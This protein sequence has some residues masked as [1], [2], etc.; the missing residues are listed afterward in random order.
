[1]TYKVT[2]CGRVPEACDLCRRPIA[3]TGAFVDGRL[4]GSGGWWAIM[5]DDCHQA[6]GCGLGTGC[7]QRYL[8][9]DNGE[10]VK[11]EG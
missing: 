7:G 11:S 9:G 5:C 8:E 6:R 2:W 3:D 4:R 1:M 10:Y